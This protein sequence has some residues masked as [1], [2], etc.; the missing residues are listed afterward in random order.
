MKDAIIRLHFD[1]QCLIY[2]TQG[3]FAIVDEVDYD[4]ISRYLW[5]VK[6]SHCT[7]S[8]YAMRNRGLKGGK[9][10][11]V[12][13]HREIMGL[14][15]DDKRQVDHIDHDTLDN[16]RSNLRIVLGQRQQSENQRNQSKHG[17]GVYLRRSGH[18]RCLVK[19]N[20]KKIHIGTYDTAKQARTARQKFLESMLVK[21]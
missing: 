16:T 15:T 21:D 13:M 8:F 19:V 3:Q 17:I 12:L 11:T 18:F 14:E 1:K 9:R 5:R 2:L 7:R 4:R 20:G 10:T 6:W